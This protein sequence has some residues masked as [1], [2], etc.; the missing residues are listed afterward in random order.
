VENH[1]LCT[2]LSRRGLKPKKLAYIQ[3][4]KTF[5]YSTKY[6]LFA[7]RQIP[8]LKLTQMT[9]TKTVGHH[10]CRGEKMFNQQPKKRPRYVIIHTGKIFKQRKNAH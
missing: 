8:Q 7:H 10:F 5:L 1:F 4:Q 9:I 6:S 2:T 3:H